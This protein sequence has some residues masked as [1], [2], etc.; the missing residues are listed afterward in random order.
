VHFGASSLGIDPRVVGGDSAGGNLAA[1]VAQHLGRSGTVL[2][3]QV[4]IYPACDVS[5]SWPSL[6]EFAEGYDLTAA[7]VEWFYGQYAGSEHADDP[8]RSPL[9]ATAYA[10]VPAYVAPAAYDPVRDDGRGYAARLVEHGVAVEFEEW[11]GVIHGFALMRAVTPATE[12]LIGHI[13]RFCRRQWN[14]T[15]TG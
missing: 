12:E 9:R 10:D 11:S 3:G 7:M 8:D 15:A 14:G 1:V 5:T 6:R 2:S 4:L 13:A